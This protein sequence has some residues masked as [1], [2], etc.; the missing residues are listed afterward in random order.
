MA[1]AKLSSTDD[2]LSL[3]VST[4]IGVSG[5]RHVR[6]TDER[7]G[8]LDGSVSGGGR[9]LLLALGYRVCSPHA[10]ADYCYIYWV[11]PGFNAIRWSERNEA[12]PKPAALAAAWAGTAALFVAAVHH[13]GGVG[14][15]LRHGVL[16]RLLLPPRRRLRHTNQ[17]KQQQ[18]DH[19]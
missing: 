5:R 12:S 3:L 14:D 16:D 17:P 9:C 13:G 19:R 10:R 1:Q 15:D 2:L 6:L 8:R 7:T 18:L 4:A 11:M